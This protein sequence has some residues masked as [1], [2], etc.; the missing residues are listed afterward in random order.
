MFQH[1]IGNWLFQLFFYVLLPLNSSF[2]I[3]YVLVVLI[4]I[5]KL[6]CTPLPHMLAIA[7]FICAL[8]VT[9]FSVGVSE[10]ILVCV[11]S[12]HP[13]QTCDCMVGLDCVL[14]A[15]EARFLQEHRL[16]HTDAP[17]PTLGLIL[18]ELQANHKLD[19]W[20]FIV[21]QT[22]VMHISY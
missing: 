17:P 8:T 9:D 22:K 3:W 2:N 21:G 7:G 13:C 11:G 5:K 20:T 4:N 16:S 12:V 19:G 15:A 18:S 14:T 10:D 6:C 1:F